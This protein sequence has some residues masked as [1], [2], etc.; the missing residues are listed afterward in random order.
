MTYPTKI[1][2]QSLLLGSIL[3]FFFR[4]ILLLLHQHTN[5]TYRI[6]NRLIVKYDDKHLDKLLRKLR[7]VGLEV[8]GVEKT[9]IFR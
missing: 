3:I 2:L 1:Q 5:S 9:K 4:G 8:H 6:E 7:L